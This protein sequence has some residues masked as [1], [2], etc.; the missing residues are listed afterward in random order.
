MAKA[1]RMDKAIVVAE[2]L[3]VLARLA[4]KSAY[5]IAAGSPEIST[6]IC[7]IY[8]PRNGF[9]QP[10][11]QASRSA[12]KHGL[13]KGWLEPD[14]TGGRLR[15]AAAGVRALRAAKSGGPDTSTLAH[16][17]HLA[18]GRY[19]G[20]LAATAQGASEGA[21]SWLRRRRDKSGRP[22]L[23]DAQ[24]SAGEKLAA[25]FWHAQMAPRVTANWSSVA[26]SQRVRRA[27]PG[28]GVEMSDAVVAARQ[29]FSRALGAVGPEL[30]G[31][32]V[33]VCCHDMGLE[34]A[35]HAAGWPQRSAKVVLELALTRLARHYGLI[36]PER[37]A[38][39]RLRHWGDEDY[40][41]TMDAWR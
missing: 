34:A 18:A 9:S 10:I 31:I 19:V 4:N 11:S 28:V 20:E 24:F 36:A 15:L 35:G 29:R 32:L 37:P 1:T 38:A 3:A 41:P 8:S 21:L 23:T 40:K 14:E 27:T 6:N 30:A 39:S 5:A 7:S 22:L 25:D 33:D 26:P 2:A 17:S 13:R 16:R 12:I